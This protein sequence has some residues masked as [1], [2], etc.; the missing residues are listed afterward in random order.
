MVSPFNLHNARRFG[1]APEGWTLI[2]QDPFYGRMSL[3][4]TR[5]AV[6]NTEKCYYFRGSSEIC[7]ACIKHI[8]YFL[9]HVSINVYRVV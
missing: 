3:G 6:V 2:G 9:R 7:T 5:Y 1:P 8:N 4:E